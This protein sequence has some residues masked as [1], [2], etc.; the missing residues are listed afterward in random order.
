MDTAKSEPTESFKGDTIY[1]V[2]LERALIA[3]S[4]ALFPNNHGLAQETFT[5]HFEEARVLIP[6]IYQYLIDTEQGDAFSLGALGAKE[7]FEVIGTTR[8]IEK[9][10]QTMHSAFEEQGFLYEPVR[11]PVHDVSTIL[12][13]QWNP[14]LRAFYMGFLPLHKTK[15]WSLTPHNLFEFLDIIIEQSMSLYVKHANEFI[16][17]EMGDH[18]WTHLKKIKWHW[19]KVSQILVGILALRY[20]EGSNVII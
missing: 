4:L 3:R 11:D 17:S 19:R 12:A 13:F 15:M 20:W 5:F 9:W 2:R 14:F 16:F 7:D 1:S 6:Q 8:R 10:R 18:R